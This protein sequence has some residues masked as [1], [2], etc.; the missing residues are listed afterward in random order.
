MKVSPGSSEYKSFVANYELNVKLP[1]SLEGINRY[2]QTKHRKKVNSVTQTTENI[3]D[4]QS[5]AIN[6]STSEL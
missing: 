5:A 2:F 4:P 6:I 1:N 3:T